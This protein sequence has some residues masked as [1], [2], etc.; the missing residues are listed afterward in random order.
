MMVMVYSLHPELKDT[1][2]IVTLYK[3]GN[4]ADCGNYKGISLLS[5]AGKL[6][7]R[8]VSFRLG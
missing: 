5:I 2:N 4:R 3:K 7:A 6:L 1:I 8:I